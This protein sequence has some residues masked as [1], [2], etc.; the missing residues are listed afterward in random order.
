MKRIARLVHGARNSMIAFLHGL[1]DGYAQPTDVTLSRNVDHLYLDDVAFTVYEWQ[2]RGIN[3]GQFLK[4]G[5]Y[6]ES[7]LEGMWP[8]RWRK[9]KR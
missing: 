8:F 3:I 6:S 5:K 7:Y 1:S 4:A 9:G 2:D